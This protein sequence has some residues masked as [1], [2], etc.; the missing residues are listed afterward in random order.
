MT[1]ATQTNK[2]LT[3]VTKRVLSE[4]QRAQ[5]PKDKVFIKLH[6]S[7]ACLS[8]PAKNTHRFQNTQI[9]LI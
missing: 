3:T 1:V 7:E 9:K 8:H 4:L 6:A 5:K 2:K